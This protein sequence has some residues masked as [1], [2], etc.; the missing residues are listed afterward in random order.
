MISKE[1]RQKFLFNTDDTGRFIVRSHRTGVTYFVEPIGSPHIQW[2]DM[3][4][5]TKQL[6]GS[7][8]Q[9]YRGS[10]DKEESLITQE[11]G[12][13]E[14]R[15]LDKGVSPLLYIDW[16]DAQYPDKK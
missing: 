12:F 13:K 11:N 5:A 1:L 10:I 6:T 16:K 3:D 15:T 7:Y 9:K 14:I 4:P 2:G 8:G